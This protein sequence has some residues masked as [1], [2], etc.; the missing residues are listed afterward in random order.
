MIVRRNIMA[1]RKLACMALIA[2]SVLATSCGSGSSN[3][4]GTSFLAVNF[5]SV[6]G[7]LASGCTVSETPISQVTAFVNDDSTFGTCI[8]T[9]FPFAV[10]TGIQLTNLLSTQFIR[11][12]SIECDYDVLQLPGYFIP[13]TVTPLSGVIDNTGDTNGEAVP[14][15]LTVGATI[16]GEDTFQYINARLNELPSFPINLA[17]NCRVTGITSA[18]NV[19]TTNTLSLNVQLTEL[20]EFF[21]TN[22]TQPLSSGSEGEGGDLAT[23]A[24]TTADP[25]TGT[26]TTTAASNSTQGVGSSTIIPTTGST[27]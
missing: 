26:T 21:D 2:L 18:G 20:P 14:E 4:Q 23:G 6:D 9:N 1:A 15:I 3:D 24:T 5:T 16:M 10:R 22:A 11:T 7:D 17:A 12:Q 25:A 27:N 13:P 8:Q 19:L